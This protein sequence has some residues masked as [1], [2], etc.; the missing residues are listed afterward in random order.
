M[1]SLK[2]THS[3]FAILM[4]SSQS[5]LMS[6]DNL[7]SLAI[8][9]YNR[10]ASDAILERKDVHSFS[11]SL[12]TGSFVIFSIGAG[13]IAAITAAYIFTRST[14]DLNPLFL[15]LLCATDALLI[16]FLLYQQH[17]FAS[18]RLGANRDYLFT[19]TRDQLWAIKWELLSSTDFQAITASSSVGWFRTQPFER[20]GMKVPFLFQ[21]R[22]VTLDDPAS[23]LV[24]LQTFLPSD[25][26]E[27]DSQ[28]TPIQPTDSDT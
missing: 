1:N 27:S 17:L 16:L 3:T 24:T 23:F 18:R 8:Q 9:L 22:L 4:S 21:S 6:H 25:H 7:P 13:L 11:Y 2:Q 20:I 15:T 19:G 14:A 10:P 28:L 12:R 26:E 5:P